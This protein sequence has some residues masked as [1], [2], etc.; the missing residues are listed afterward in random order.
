MRQRPAAVGPHVAG[1]RQPGEGLG[2]EAPLAAAVVGQHPR[3][4]ILHLAPAARAAAHAGR[5]HWNEEEEL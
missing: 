3:L 4:A 1:V 5:W 2:Q